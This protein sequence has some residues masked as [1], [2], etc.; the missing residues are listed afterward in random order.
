[1]FVFKWVFWKEIC[2]KH[3]GF[4]FVFRWPFRVSSFQERSVPVRSQILSRWRYCGLTV[5]FPAILLSIFE[6]FVIQRILQNLQGTPRGQQIFRRG[7]QILF[8]H[9][10]WLILGNWYGSEVSSPASL[11]ART[12]HELLSISD[13]PPSPAPFPWPS[14]FCCRFL[15]FSFSDGFCRI[16]RE[17]PWRIFRWGNPNL[18]VASPPPGRVVIFEW[19]LAGDNNGKMTKKARA[20]LVQ[21]IYSSNIPKQNFNR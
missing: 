16:C 15:K 8:T 2:G 3:S 10:D 7:N 14:W 12:T 4:G 1:M 21:W 13:V 11:G 20:R 9:D 18:I 19:F 6:N 17:T 5:V